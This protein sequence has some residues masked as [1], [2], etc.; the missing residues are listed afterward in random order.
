MWQITQAGGE[1]GL[2]D[3][4]NIVTPT[5]AKANQQL[6]LMPQLPVPLKFA[7]ALAVVQVNF[8]C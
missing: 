2:Y 5:Q 1:G 6:L 7:S 3:A 8:T 4:V